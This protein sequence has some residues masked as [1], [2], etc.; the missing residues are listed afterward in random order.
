MYHVWLDT[1]SRVRIPSHVF[2][3]GLVSLAILLF[4]SLTFSQ[5]TGFS[6]RSNDPFK[7]RIRIV[8]DVQLRG[9]ENIETLAIL[10]LLATKSRTWF[11]GF[12]NSLNSSIGLPEQI[13]DKAAIARDTETIYL[14][15]REKGYL[16]AKVSYSIIDDSSSLEL[17]QQVN[18]RNRLLPAED[19]EDFP[20]IE[21]TVEFIVSEGK[22]YTVGG[23]TFEGLEE[24][25][26]ELLDKATSEIGIEL[27]KPYDAAD[28]KAEYT[29]VEKYLE[30]NGYPFFTRDSVFVD[31]QEG[32]E[33]VYITI[34]FI[35]GR[36]YKVGDIRIIY[37]EGSDTS[38]VVAESTI[39]RQLRFSTGEWVRNSKIS[40]SELNLYQLGTFDVA[41][42][43]I[44][45]SGVVDLPESERYAIAVP[46]VVSL[47][48]RPTAD[49]AIGTALSSGTV[50]TAMSLKGAYNNRN[51]FRGAESFSVSTSY[52]IFP[53]NQRSYDASVSL[54]LPSMFSVDIPLQI[55]G[56][57]SG[58]AQFESET[59]ALQLDINAQSLSFLTR[60][61]L[62]RIPEYR[63]TLGGGVS[64]ERVSSVIRDSS[65]TADFLQIS[66]DPQLN[67]IFST[68]YTLDG[69]NDIFNPS[70]GSS[71]SGSL[72]LGVPWFASILPGELPSASYWKY[73]FQ[74]RNFL[75]VV[76]NSSVFA[77]RLYFG[78]ISLND[79]SA[80]RDV[81]TTK[82][83]LGGG[84]TSFRGWSTRE[85]LV[86]DRETNSILGGYTTIGVSTEFRFAPFQYDVELTSWQQLSAPIR[87]AIFTDFGN[88]WNKET[89][90]L[91]KNFSV[92]TGIGFRY[93]TP[94][95]PLRIDW[96]FKFYDP[97]YQQI[98]QESFPTTAEPIW[99]FQRPITWSSL[100]DLSSIGFTIGNAF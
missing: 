85:L 11:E 75:P 53:F 8:S 92:T 56:I 42:I 19:K 26:I 74:L 73:S 82:K 90:I 100:F 30:E 31:R 35:T 61:D 71:F 88:V 45:T 3:G 63:S 24:L 16:D 72:E 7:N 28:V 17:W 5:V 80:N 49:V 36:R 46:L 9:N 39:R 76:S 98:A 21:T 15:Y 14:L 1:R 62:F 48:M 32:S 83:F 67:L 47:R 66:K 54:G 27:N 60:V 43:G 79:T 22:R 57:F 55:S 37:E 38:N 94:F 41:R 52:Q 50:G 70:R 84:L 78:K 86:S 33:R 89:P 13:V 91:L 4:A 23:F 97:Y 95:G 59:G 96:G 44:D 2:F 51:I 99:I 81:P 20:K 65:L 58:F 12:L 40:E 34:Q 87:L 93:N 25:P 29:R 10:P 18:E 77:S 6:A 69:T 64:F 68:D